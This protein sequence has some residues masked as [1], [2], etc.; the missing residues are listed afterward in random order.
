MK[1]RAEKGEEDGRNYEWEKS[2]KRTT[3]STNR[4]RLNIYKWLIITNKYAS[5]DSRNCTISCEICCSLL[6]HAITKSYDDTWPNMQYLV[7]SHVILRKL[8]LEN[9]LRSSEEC[10]N[11][12]LSLSNAIIGLLESSVSLGRGE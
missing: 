4:E 11:G 5:R 12:G 10:E 7:H 9:R 6:L 1:G 3:K 2:E 8:S